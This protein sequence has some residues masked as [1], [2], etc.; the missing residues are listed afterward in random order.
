MIAC[1]LSY[2]YDLTST[3]QA[4][5]TGVRAP[6]ADG[7]PPPAGLEHLS[8]FR[9]S[10]Q[11]MWNYHLLKDAFPSLRDDPEGRKWKGNLGGQADGGNAGATSG[12]VIPLVYGFVDQASESFTSPS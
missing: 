4:N 7:P 5:L 2:T 12:W 11:Y 6:P 1:P 8:A 3:L 10:T 9:V